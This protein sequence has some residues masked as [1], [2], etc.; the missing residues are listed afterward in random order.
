MDPHGI[1]ILYGTDDDNIILQV[2]HHFKLVLFPAQ[3]RFFNEYLVYHTA[4]DSPG[5]NDFKFFNIKDNAAPRSPQG[6]TGTYDQG[7]ADLFGYGTGLFHG[8][9]KSTP[10][11]ILADPAHRLLKQFPVFRLVNC[12]IVGTDHGNTMGI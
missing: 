10:R 6:E 1:K 9:G 4:L 7:I 5:G 12:F 11:Q 2:P 8:M 3:N